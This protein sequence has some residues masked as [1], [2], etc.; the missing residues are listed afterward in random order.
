MAVFEI[1]GN[2]LNSDMNI[3]VTVTFRVSIYEWVELTAPEV[4]H[5]YVEVDNK[6]S[7]LR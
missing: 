4:Y 7:I 3:I 1:T 5:N 6:K 2:Y